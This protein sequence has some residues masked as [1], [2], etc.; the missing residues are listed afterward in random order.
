M[1]RGPWFTLVLVLLIGGQLHAMQR[2]VGNVGASHS[3]LLTAY[4]LRQGMTRPHCLELWLEKN[5]DDKWSGIQTTHDAQDGRGVLVAG[6]DYLDKEGITSIKGA[7]TINTLGSF[8]HGKICLVRL[9]GEQEM[10]EVD[11]TQG[12]FP[13]DKLPESRS[14]PEKDT[15]CPTTQDLLYVRKLRMSTGAK[16]PFR[17]FD[18]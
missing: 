18:Q 4:L 2:S 16:D 17:L 9:L 1:Y 3:K 12:W 6:L 14:L 7:V 10:I 15:L 13:V 11:D 5:D 8:K